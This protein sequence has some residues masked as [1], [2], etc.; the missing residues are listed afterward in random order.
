M[1]VCDLYDYKIYCVIGFFIYLAFI[2]LICMYAIC[3][4]LHHK[5]IQFFC[6]KIHRITLKFDAHLIIFAALNYYSFAIIAL[7]IFAFALQFH[8]NLKKPR[9]F[10]CRSSSCYRFVFTKKKK[11]ILI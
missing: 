1:C 6:I 2:N 8:S 5:N 9:L 7:S 3:I 10:I 11:N 4:H